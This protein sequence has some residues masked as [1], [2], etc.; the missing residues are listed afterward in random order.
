MLELFIYLII[1]TK[2]SKNIIKVKEFI[3]SDIK[4]GF[5]K[6]LNENVFCEFGTSQAIPIE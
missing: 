1:L 4:I 3:K 5:T 2:D 6:D